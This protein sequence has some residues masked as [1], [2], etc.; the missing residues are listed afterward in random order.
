[1]FKGVKESLLWP[2]LNEKKV[3]K[4][5]IQAIRQDEGEVSIYWLQGILIWLS[6]AVMNSWLADSTLFLLNG[7]DHVVGEKFT[8]RRGPNDPLDKCLK[9]S[10]QAYE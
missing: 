2:T 1:M 10:D 7:Y 3:A 8:G 4:R 9:C 6:K 5:V